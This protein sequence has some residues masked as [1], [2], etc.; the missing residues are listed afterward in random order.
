MSICQTFLIADFLRRMFNFWC[1]TI[2]TCE[3]NRYT[4]KCHSLSQRCIKRWCER[5]CCYEITTNH[6]GRRA[7]YLVIL[8]RC[9][10]ILKRIFL[11][12]KSLYEKGVLAEITVPELK[13][14]SRNYSLHRWERQVKLWLLICCQMTCSVTWDLAKLGSYPVIFQGWE[15]G[16]N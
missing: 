2:K 8:T 4:L 7:R 9:E 14:C 6:K 11:N 13:C 15:R 3:K 10:N 12:F 1:S 16:R 5:S